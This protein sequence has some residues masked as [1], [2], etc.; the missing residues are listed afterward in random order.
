MAA[1]SLFGGS[2][3]GGGS[4][5]VTLSDDALSLLNH[6]LTDTVEGSTSGGS[7]GG[8]SYVMG[9]GSNGESQGGILPGAAPI[10]GTIHDGV[11]QLTLNLPAGTGLVFEGV[12]GMTP[13]A[14]GSFL[15]SVVDSYHAPAAQSA[16][17]HAAVQQLV[18]AVK[19]QGVTDVVVRVFDVM[20]G[21][22]AQG[23][24]A[25]GAG[26]NDIVIDAG[27]NAG[28]QLFAVNLLHADEPVVLRGVENAVVANAGTVEVEGNTSIH[29]VGDIAAQNIIG[30]GGNDTLVGG[31]GNDTLT[32]GLGSDVFGFSALGHV[33]LTDFDVA[34]DTAAFSSSG[35]TNIQQLAALVTSVENDAA[36]VT[37]N[38]GPDASITLVGVSA[39]EIT[40]DLIKFTF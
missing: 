12:D 2:D 6:F 16:S 34:H 29:L 39:S 36:G 13:D 20:H 25:L 30:G 27:N 23:N 4:I 40:S 18:D 5:P 33:T 15:N 10:S 9:H 14:W 22:S 11:L 7:L 37:F 19:S 26:S 8:S 17:L 38:F 3:A 32:G 35:I 21:S 24:G 1:D 31:G 28:S